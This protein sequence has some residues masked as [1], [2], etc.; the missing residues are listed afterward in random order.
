MTSFPAGYQFGLLATWV[1]NGKQGKKFIHAA[2]PSATYK[3][4]WTSWRRWRKINHSRATA[5]WEL[6]TYF[7]WSVAVWSIC[8]SS[9]AHF[10]P[11]VSFCNAS[12][13]MTWPQTSRT[14]GLLSVL[15]W[16]SIGHANIEWN[17]HSG[18][19]SISIWTHS[20]VQVSD[21]SL[22]NWIIRSLTN[23]THT[24]Q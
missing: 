8:G 9:G 4:R 20:S 16:R 22:Q 23:T 5:E 11:L 14:G 2:P 15:C 18:P 24:Q 7:C 21:H 10:E 3:W 19:R 6:W 13:D 17:R 12:R 1:K